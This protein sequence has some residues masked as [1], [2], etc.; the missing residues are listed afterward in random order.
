[1][2]LNK[3]YNRPNEW[4]PHHVLIAITEN[5]SIVIGGYFGKACVFIYMLL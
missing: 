4:L 1:M 5:D 2:Q 3:V